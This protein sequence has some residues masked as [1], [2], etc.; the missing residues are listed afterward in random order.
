[1]QKPFQRI[2]FKFVKQFLIHTT[3]FE[4]SLI[5]DIVGVNIELHVAILA[6]P[7]IF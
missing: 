1:M 5:T 6:S 3:Y 2:S 4:D 7:D